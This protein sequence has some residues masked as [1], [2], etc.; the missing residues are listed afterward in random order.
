MWWLASFA[1]KLQRPR[2]L[3][4]AI[5]YLHRPT[6]TNRDEIGIRMLTYFIDARIRMLTDRFINA[7]SSG[8]RNSVLLLC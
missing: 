7:I 1:Y 6:G 2:P 8:D 3:T 4:F 5:L